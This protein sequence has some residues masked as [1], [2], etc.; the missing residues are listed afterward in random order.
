MTKKW[1]WLTIGAVGL[2]GFGVG[3]VVAKP[4]PRYELLDEPN[5]VGAPA[6]QVPTLS[7]H[8]S[9]EAEQFKAV[10]RDV[11]KRYGRGYDELW[12]YFQSPG[13][14]P[15]GGHVVQHVLCIWKKDGSIEG[16]GYA[17]ALGGQAPVV[18]SEP[19]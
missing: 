2:A 15:G 5:E 16:T 18:R 19:W 14:R 13:I 6:A 1:L 7:V 12:V 3:L 17:G 11:V 10:T 8:V 9:I 4:C